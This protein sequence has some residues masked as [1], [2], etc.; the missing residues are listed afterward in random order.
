MADHN[1][2]NVTGSVMYLVN[3]ILTVTEIQ[4]QSS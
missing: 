4:Y 1:L 3:E 2:K